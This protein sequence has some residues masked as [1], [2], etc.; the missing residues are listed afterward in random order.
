MNTHTNQAVVV[1]S[2]F[3]LRAVIAFCR[4]ATQLCVPYYIIAASSTDPIFKTEFRNRVVHTRTTPELCIHKVSQ[5]LDTICMKQRVGRLLILPSTEYLNRFLLDNKAELARIGH[6]IPLVDRNLYIQISN[7]RS[8]AKTCVDH[9]LPVPGEYK[10]IPN[11][12]PFVAKPLRY[13]STKTGYQIRPWLIDSQRILDRF[14]RTEDPSDYFYQ[15]FVTGRSIYLLFHVSREGKDVLFSQEN[16]IQQRGGGSII[17]ARK[18]NCHSKPIAKRYLEMLRKLNFAG[19]IMI[20]LKKTFDG[21]YLMIEA[22]PR[23][24]GPFQLVVDNNVPILDQFLK[25]QGFFVDTSSQ[26]NPE[27][28][29]YYWSG[30]LTPSARP[31]MYHNFSEKEFRDISKTL[32]HIDIFNRDDTRELYELELEGTK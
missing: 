20:E 11:T 10:A 16:L 8:F 15:E 28:A 18:S 2:G 13:E 26:Q 14:L 17:L 30:G 23:L 32:P 22:N 24:W 3:N 7:K 27:T 1:F 29:Y 9:G 6:E 5:W 21:Q 19:V 25:E 12:L 31:L 4:R